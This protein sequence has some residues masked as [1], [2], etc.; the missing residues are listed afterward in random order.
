MGENKVGTG[1]PT[2]GEAR[3]RDH[4][5]NETSLQEMS[6]EQETETES[7]QEQ[8]DSNQRAID[9]IRGERDEY[10]D[11][12]LRKQAE[13]ENYKKRVNREKEEL[14]LFSQTEVLKQL[15][16]I[17]DAFEKGVHSLDEESGDTTLET[18]REGYQ[19]ILKQFR[20]IFEKLEVT[21]VPG[22][23]T[24]F[25]PNVHEAVVREVTS[26]HPEGKIMDEYRKGYRIKNRLLRPAQVKVAVEPEKPQST[27]SD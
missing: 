7:Q 21:E 11:R 5:G 8:A 2:E 4:S 10:Y 24:Q 17:V 18:Y 9:E 27:N 22:L 20:S 3:D 6:E 15:L 23:G 12:L 1:E 26:Q 19:L 14:Y 25:D 16:V 13:F